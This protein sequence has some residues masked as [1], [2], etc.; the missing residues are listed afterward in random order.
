[1]AEVLSHPWVFLWFHDGIHLI[2]TSSLPDVST[3][4]SIFAPQRG[5]QSGQL[6]VSACAVSP[7]LPLRF[8]L[9]CATR[10]ASP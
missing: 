7:A 10:R 2:C 8:L 4:M 5:E 6:A 1:M 9:P 3:R